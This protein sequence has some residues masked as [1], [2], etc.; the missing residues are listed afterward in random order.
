MIKQDIKE[1]I[2]KTNNLNIKEIP[3]INKNY[4]ILKKYY[5][6]VLNKDKKLFV[7]S[8]DQPTPI[9]CVEEMISKIPELFWKKKKIKILDPCCGCGNFPL[10]IFFKLRKYHSK[11]YIFDN[12]LYF[13]DINKNRLNILKKIFNYELNIFT[14]DYLKINFNDMKFDLIVG[15]PP[16]AKLLDNGKRTSKNHNMI[17]LF[18]KK[19]FEILKEKGYLLFITPDNWM[20]ISNRNT[21]IMELTSKQIHYIN[22]HIAK[23]YFKKIGSSFVWYLIENTKFYK[24][25]QIEGIFNKKLYKGSVKSEI[26]RYI[27]VFYNSIIQS[28]L[29]KTIDCNNKKFIIETSSDLHKYTKKKLISNNKDN[30]FKYKLIH[31]PNQIV[32]SSRPHKYQKDYKVFIP[33]T[34]YYRTFIGRCGFTQSICV[35]RC[36]NKKEA[37]HFSH[38]LSH[39]LYRFI[40]NICRYGNFNN[41]R[42][43]QKFPYQDNY[44]DIYKN[45]NITSQEIDFIEKNLTK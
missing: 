12:I 2:N 28:I 43:L 6:E 38:I 7:T 25:I 16:Y 15:N 37:K 23:K 30:K 17:G 11:K 8:N 45:L 40:N 34:T 26:R 14:D 3:T 5:D 10:S 31:T 20:S 44:E 39:P 24:D 29:N 13:N 42:I 1:L 36:N 32:W 35:L 4:S 18:I 41:I 22:I 21:L 33:T 19:S 27:P 9:D